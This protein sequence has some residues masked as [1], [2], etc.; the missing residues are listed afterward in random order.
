MD[1]INYL[2]ERYLDQFVKSNDTDIN[3][4]RNRD[5]QLESTTI[6]FS[7]IIQVIEM[8]LLPRLLYLFISLLILIPET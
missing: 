1:A 6:D 4:N 2:G 3:S 8:N 7:S 5:P